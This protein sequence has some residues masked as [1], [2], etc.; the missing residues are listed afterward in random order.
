MANPR[1]AMRVPS[2]DLLGARYKFEDSPGF[3]KDFGDAV[4]GKVLVGV[5]WSTGFEHKLWLTGEPV[6]L[7]KIRFELTGSFR[8]NGTDS[9]RVVILP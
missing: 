5:N 6:P 2:A 7:Y 9:R 1:A 3:E 4:N 8:Q